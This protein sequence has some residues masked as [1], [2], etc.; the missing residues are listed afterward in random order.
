LLRHPLL[1]EFFSMRLRLAALTLAIAGIFAFCGP[2]AAATE[3]L[4]VTNHTDT[5]VWMTQYADIGAAGWAINSQCTPRMI[6]AHS[7]TRCER[8]SINKNGPWRLRFE[9]DFAGKRYDHI[10]NYWYDGSQHNFNTP[11]DP[12]SYFYVCRDGGGFYWS[13]SSGC[14][15]HNNS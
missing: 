7:T 5:P 14:K 8:Y 6:G 12:N 10:T 15:T 13:Y 3:W 4:V 11:G 2:A 1:Q 9:V